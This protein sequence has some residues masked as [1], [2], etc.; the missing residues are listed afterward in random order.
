MTVR[1]LLRNLIPL[2]VFIGLAIIAVFAITGTDWGRN[3]ARGRFEALLQ[4][5]S[6][7][8]VRIGS[9]TGNLRHGFTLHDLVITD[10]AHKPFVKA[11]EVWAKYS[12]STFF[13]KKSRWTV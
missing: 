12:I 10:S 2:Y 8:I 7:G 4:N 3:F 9:V 6:H 1:R 5:N 13:G 11:K